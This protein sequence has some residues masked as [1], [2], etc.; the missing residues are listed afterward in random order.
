MSSRY[1][2]LF[3]LIVASVP[4]SVACGTSEPPGDPVLVDGSSTVLP[5]AEAAAGEYLRKHPTR[6]VRVTLSSTGVGLRRFCAGELDIADASRHITPQEIAACQATGVEFLEIPIAYDAISVVVNR[7]NTWATSMTTAELRALWEPAADGTVTK[8]SQ[9]RKDWPDREI[10]L[11]GP[12]DES[13]T[14][15][16]FNEV[17]SGA[18][19]ASRKDYS[20]HVDDNE[21]ISAVEADEDALAYVGFTYYEQQEERL[22]AVAIDDLDEQIGPGPIEPTLTNVQRGV[23]RPL[24]RPLFVYVR[25]SALDRPEVASFADYFVRF[26]TEMVQRAGGAPLTSRESELALKRFTDRVTG[27]M[28]ANPDEGPDVSLQMRLSRDGQ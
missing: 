1:A 2:L 12:D 28:Y 25:K 18:P 23:Y 6:T 24:S 13:G 26:A 17:I 16:Y 19:K 15:D 9:V 7:A 11:V 8:W 3:F 10:H 21:I 14:F 27:T 5:F 4:G 22:D 20:P